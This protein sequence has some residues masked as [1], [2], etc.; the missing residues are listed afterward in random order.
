MEYAKQNAEDFVPTEPSPT[1]LGGAI[2]RDPIATVRTLV[3]VV[4]PCDVHTIAY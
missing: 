1:D 3:R 2:K 4:S